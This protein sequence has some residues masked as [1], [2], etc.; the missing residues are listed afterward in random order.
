LVLTG[1][2]CGFVD[3]QRGD[4]KYF[5]VCADEKLSAFVELERDVLTVMFYLESIQADPR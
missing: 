2:Q 3:A 1:A 5:I 4:Q